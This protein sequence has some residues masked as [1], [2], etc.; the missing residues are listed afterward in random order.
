MQGTDG[1]AHQGCAASAALED[2]MPMRAEA[3]R[4]ERQARVI[5][6]DPSRRLRKLAEASNTYVGNLCEGAVPP[7][8]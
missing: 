8:G 4:E 7:L 5:L 3:K 6:G 1:L 2:A